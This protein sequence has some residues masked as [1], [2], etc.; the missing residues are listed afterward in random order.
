MVTKAT[1][2]GN[3]L[4]MKIGYMKEYRSINQHNSDFSSKLVSD[5]LLSFFSAQ[6]GCIR[7]VTS[8]HMKETIVRI[9]L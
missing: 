1:F 5:L 6:N 9:E 4:K 3:E 7:N 2:V 8:S